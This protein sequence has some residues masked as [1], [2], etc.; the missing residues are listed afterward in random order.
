MSCLCHRRHPRFR[1][2]SLWPSFPL[3]GNTHKGRKNPRSPLRHEPGNAAAKDPSG[4][5]D[6]NSPEPGASSCSWKMTPRR[7]LAKLTAYAV[8]PLRSCGNTNLTTPSP[9]TVCTA[10]RTRYPIRGAFR[11]AYL[12]G[13][14]VPV[15]K[16]PIVHRSIGK[17]ITHCLLLIAPAGWIIRT[18]TNVCARPALSR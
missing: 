13:F 15:C 5:M 18:P 4:H 17:C 14:V 7:L 11:L 8:L 1:D 2:F 10:S 12:M 16:S 3:C 6:R 9:W